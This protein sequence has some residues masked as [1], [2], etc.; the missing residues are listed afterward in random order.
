[1]RNAAL[2]SDAN[3]EVLAASPVPPR[4]KIDNVSATGSNADR[5]TVLLLDLACQAVHQS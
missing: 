5:Q 4:L 2:K 1:M 3:R